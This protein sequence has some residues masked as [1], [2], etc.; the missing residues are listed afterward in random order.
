VLE[1]EKNREVKSV[2]ELEIF[3]DEGERR[4]RVLC[5]PVMEVLLWMWWVWWAARVEALFKNV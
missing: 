3:R 1:V 2:E 5:R 4:S